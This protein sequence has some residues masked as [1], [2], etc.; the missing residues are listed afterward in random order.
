[1]KLALGTVQ[2]GLDYG[3]SNNNGRVGPEEIAEIIACCR[4]LGI[5]TIDTA[6][7]YGVAEQRLGDVGVGDLA[8]VGKVSLE[9]NEADDLSQY[10]L[11]RISASLDRLGAD[12]FHGLLLHTPKS[13]MGDAAAAQQIVQALE[14]VRDA[15]LTAKI[16]ASTYSPE[17][18]ISLYT[19]FPFDIVQIPLC[20][21]DARWSHSDVLGI[22]ER[23]GVEVHVRSVFLQG[24][25]LMSLET[26]PTWTMKW[27]RLLEGWHQW[28]TDQGTD[29]VSACIALADTY[30]G[31]EKIVVGVENVGQLRQVHAGLLSTVAELPVHLQ[32]MDEDLLDASRWRVAAASA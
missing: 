27:R 9:G 14:K 25:L 4:D 12:R 15:G 23:R 3:V 31:V 18:T 8:I 6:E 30:S 16:G 7:A 20:P 13:L 11:N 2:F 26:L 5:D 24:I 10:L 17:Q 29:P 28:I 19:K 1:M 21:L 32:T 22:L